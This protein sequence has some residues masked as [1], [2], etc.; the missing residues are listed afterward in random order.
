MVYYTL[1]VILCLICTIIYF[2]MEK[3]STNRILGTMIM[4]IISIIPFINLLIPIIC[5]FS[6]FFK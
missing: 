5:I 4:V 6:L 1:G 2:I 3:N